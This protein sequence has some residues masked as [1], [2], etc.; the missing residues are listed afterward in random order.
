ME[1]KEIFEMEH[2]T[3]SAILFFIAIAFEL[4]KWVLDQYYWFEIYE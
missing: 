1:K 4:S 3:G 2:F